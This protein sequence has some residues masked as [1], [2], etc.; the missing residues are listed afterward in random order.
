[1]SDFDPYH[2]WLGIPRRDQPPNHYRLLGIEVFESDPDVIDAAA[3]QRASFVRQCVT[4]KQVRHSQQILNEIASARLTLL[5][6]NE[7][8]NYDLALRKQMAAEA[9]IRRREE[10]N[11]HA[12]PSSKKTSRRRPVI[13]QTESEPTHVTSDGNTRLKFRLF[14]TGIAC[15]FALMVAGIVVFSTGSQQYAAKS[16]DSINSQEN[17]TGRDETPTRSSANE[18]PLQNSTTAI[19]HSDS[20]RTE[21]EVAT[22]STNDSAASIKPSIKLEPLNAVTVREGE[23]MTLTAKVRS[24]GLE[25]NRLRYYFTAPPPTGC[26]LD[27]TTGVIKWLPTE[28]QGPGEFNLFVSVGSLDYPLLKDDGTVLVRVLEVNEPPMLEPIDDRTIDEGTPFSFT[29]KARDIDEPAQALSYYLKSNDTTSAVIN[30]QTGKFEW[31]PQSTDVNRRFTFRVFVNDAADPNNLQYRDF[32]IAVRRAALADLI[33]VQNTYDYKWTFFSGQNSDELQRQVENATSTNCRPTCVSSYLVDAQQRFAS[34]WIAD[35]TRWKLHVGMDSAARQ[36]LYD[37]QRK[38][39]KTVW[40][41][42]TGDRSNVIIVESLSQPAWEI[43]NSMNSATIDAYI[44]N[45]NNNNTNTNL[46]L[47]AVWQEASGR[48]GCH[49][50]AG[51]QESMFWKNLTIESFPR[52]IKELRQGFRPVY[53]DGV[54]LGKD[55]QYTLVLINDGTNPKWD[56]QLAVPLGELEKRLDTIRDAGM[57]PLAID[58]E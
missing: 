38:T 47:I 39:D 26:S 24:T 16:T 11:S 44:E 8:R 23:V 51:L 6:E 4:G 20:V 30:A 10:P 52:A 17:N 50:I 29:I 13:D 2:K 14:L 19:T 32:S 53:L 40:T 5:K 1:M 49:L 54:G 21:S 25:A 45:V 42:F 43:R 9:D 7:K 18:S 35:Q 34:V 46:Q 37:S 28:S 27:A 41:S 58:V 33:L 31:S 56:I 57:I 22:I 3:E 36:R 48:Y 55:R 15:A 12:S